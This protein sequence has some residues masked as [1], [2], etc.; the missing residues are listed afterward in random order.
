MLRD[1][2]PR[3]RWISTKLSLREIIV[4]SV[5]PKYQK[6]DDKKSR[7]HRLTLLNLKTVGVH[8]ED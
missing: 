1:T 4:S 8:H 6:F 5:P 7:L 2:A 3:G